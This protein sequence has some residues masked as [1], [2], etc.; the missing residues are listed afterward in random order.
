MVLGKAPIVFWT[1]R[2][3]LTGGAAT[4]DETIPGLLT[5]DVIQ[6]TLL[7]VTTPASL[8]ISAAYQ[9][10]DTVRLTFSGLPGATVVH[11]TVYRP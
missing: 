4:E 3:T 6:A 2:L 8:F 11:V 10:A 7:S 5:S 9:A 1:G